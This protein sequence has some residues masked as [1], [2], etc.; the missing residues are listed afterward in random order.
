M[1]NLKEA[2]WGLPGERAHLPKKRRENI[3]DIF[4]TCQANKVLYLYVHYYFR[5]CIES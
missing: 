2:F 3:Q 5:Q 1:M 4:R